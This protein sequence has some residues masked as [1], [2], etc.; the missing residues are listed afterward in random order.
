M[1]RVG[2]LLRKTIIRNLSQKTFVNL[3]VPNFLNY[4]QKVVSRFL[5]GVHHV[6]LFLL[7]REKIR[8]EVQM[9]GGVYLMTLVD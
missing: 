2:T 1:R 8:T 4:I 7:I 6:N 5:L 3:P 9:S